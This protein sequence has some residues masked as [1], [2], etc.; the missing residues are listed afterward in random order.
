MV[1]LVTFLSLVTSGRERKCRLSM[2]FMPNVHDRA[3]P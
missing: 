1:G 3:G 2:A